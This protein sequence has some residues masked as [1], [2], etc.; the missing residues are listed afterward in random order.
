MDFTMPFPDYRLIG[1]E[2]S[3]DFCHSKIPTEDRE[4]ISRQAWG[5]GADAARELFCAEQGLYDFVKIAGAYGLRIDKIDKDYIVGNR[6]C[7]SDYFPKQKC[8]RLYL[9]SIALWS[10]Q[11]RL[12]TDAATQLILSHEFFHYLEYTKLGP[13]SRIYR[14]PA[15]TIGKLRIGRV[16]VRALSEIGAHAFA[17]TYYELASCESREQASHVSRELVSCE[18]REQASCASH[19]LAS[20]ESRERVSCE[21]HT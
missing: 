4:R 5:I 3:Y 20:C 13:T 15:L 6:R 12:D 19:K 1:K 14:A 16:G 21:S 10:G 17:R 7:F 18:S 9:R 8:V 11:N 2:L